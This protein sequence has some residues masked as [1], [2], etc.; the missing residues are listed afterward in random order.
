M[1]KFIKKDKYYDMSYTLYKRDII[2]KDDFEI[3]M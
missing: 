1:I 3:E 2:G